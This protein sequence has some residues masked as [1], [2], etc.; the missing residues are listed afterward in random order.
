MRVEG[1]L[2]VIF[3]VY[4]DSLIYVSSPQTARDVIAHIGADCIVI[5][6]RHDSQPDAVGTSEDEGVEGANA[7]VGQ[8]YTHQGSR[9]PTLPGRRVK[10][11]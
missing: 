2:A 7:G 9:V 10:R 4:R 5:R 11:Q 3:T 6:S 1:V 8:Y